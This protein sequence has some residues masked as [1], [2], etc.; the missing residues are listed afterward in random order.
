[1]VANKQGRL[2]EYKAM[3]EA[4]PIGYLNS[5]LYTELQLTLRTPDCKLLA[6]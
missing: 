2:D 5:G 6:C 1:M 3:R 4:D